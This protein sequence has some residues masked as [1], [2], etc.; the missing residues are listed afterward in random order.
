ES[1]CRAWLSYAQRKVFRGGCF[2]A[3]ASAEFDSR[4]G[5]IRDRVASVMAE[6]MN[7]LETAVRKAQGEGDLRD[8]LDVSQLAFE[9]NAMMFAANW[10]FQLY[11]D[12]RVFARAKKGIEGI[13]RRGQ[14]SMKNEE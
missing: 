2:F 13:I 8:D 4:P 14:C 3:A 5:V 11:G 12:K 7:A 9:I 10:A 1:L 6:W